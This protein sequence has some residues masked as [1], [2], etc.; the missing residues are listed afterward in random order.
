MG[1]DPCNIGSEDNTVYA[2]LSMLFVWTLSGVLAI[3]LCSQYKR[4]RPNSKMSPRSA[5][6]SFVQGFL[7]VYT[8]MFTGLV[9]RIFQGLKSTTP[10]T[11]AVAGASIAFYIVIVPAMI[12]CAMYKMQHVLVHPKHMTKVERI[13]LLKDHR[14]HSHKRMFGPFF[15]QYERKYWWFEIAE[16]L[17]KVLLTGVIGVLPSAVSQCA[18]AVVVSVAFLILMDRT[19]PLV[20]DIDDFVQEQF[21]VM[22]CLI[23]ITGLVSELNPDSSTRAVGWAL[24]ALTCASLLCGLTALMCVFPKFKRK[25]GDPLA[26]CFAPL[27]SVLRRVRSVVCGRCT[28]LARKVKV[29]PGGESGKGGGEG[30]GGEE[31]KEEEEEE[32]D[33][34]AILRASHTWTK[35]DNFHGSGGQV[36]VNDETGEAS[37]YDPSDIVDNVERMMREDAAL[38]GGGERQ[39]K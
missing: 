22:L 29:A 35:F 9:A 12:L 23:Y 11:V 28:S 36:W 27:T 32:E 30:D 15:L 7:L 18:F 17:R 13:R 19:Q 20:E 26:R 39:K 3:S 38:Y 8:L 10:L 24:N 25:V 33:E 14:H 16:L 31:G 37:I 1:A 2:H 5:R 6:T 4:S 34:E 21:Q